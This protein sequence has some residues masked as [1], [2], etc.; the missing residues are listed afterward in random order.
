MKQRICS[1]SENLGIVWI[2]ALFPPVFYRTES[3][4]TL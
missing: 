3:D 4:P 2:Q 1:L